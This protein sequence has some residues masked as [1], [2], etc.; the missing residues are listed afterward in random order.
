MEG[1]GR[2]ILYFGYRQ[3]ERKVSSNSIVGSVIK[4][5]IGYRSSLKAIAQAP[6]YLFPDSTRIR[7]ARNEVRVHEGAVRVRL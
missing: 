2:A 1:S 3:S 4:T 7:I 5:V 6:A